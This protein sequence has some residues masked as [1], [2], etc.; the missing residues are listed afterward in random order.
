MQGDTGRG[1]EGRG[2]GERLGLPSPPPE[3]EGALGA[4]G[5]GQR[6]APH[7]TAR[8][9]PPALRHPAGTW[10]GLLPAVP[11]SLSAPQRPGHPYP[12]LPQCLR[13]PTPSFKHQHPRLLRHRQCPRRTG[14]GLQRAIRPPP[15]RPTF[16]K[17]LL[18]PFGATFCSLRAKLVRSCQPRLLSLL[19]LPSPKTPP[20]SSS[21]EAAYQATWARVLPKLVAAPRPFSALCL[22][23]WWYRTQPGS[24]SFPPKLSL[25]ASRILRFLVFLLISLTPFLPLHPGSHQPT[26]HQQFSTREMFVWRH[27]QLSHSGEVLW[28]EWAEVA[29]D[30]AKQ[31]DARPTPHQKVI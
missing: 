28:H 4:A 25:L 11:T 19:S 6:W 5:G 8:R 17:I 20:A 26:L 3:P 16:R 24:H 23:S 27:F 29:E 13:A 12:L 2:R 31:D 14:R 18:K 30:A 7:P 22:A 15:S 1:R 21:W 10:G 9:E